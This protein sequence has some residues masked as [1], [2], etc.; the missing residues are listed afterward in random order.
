MLWN[1]AGKYIWYTPVMTDEIWRTNKINHDIKVDKE[2]LTT[3]YHF[4]VKLSCKRKFLILIYKVSETSNNTK[5]WVHNSEMEWTLSQCHVAPACKYQV[6]LYHDIIQ[7]PQ[8]DKFE[9]KFGI[10]S[11]ASEPVQTGS[12][13]SS[14]DWTLDWTSCSVPTGAQTFNWTLVRF[15]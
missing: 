4:D 10:G 3:Q 13:K 15:R 5:Y 9:S 8:C 1:Y 6:Y 14:P 11:E 7:R 12:A 2:E